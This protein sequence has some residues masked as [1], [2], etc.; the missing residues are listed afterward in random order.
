MDWTRNIDAYCERVGAAFWSEPINAV[1]NLAFIVA[2][3]IIWRRLA[4]QTL[5]IA[6]VL[7]IILGLIGVGSFLFHTYAQAWSGLADVL[8]I[9]GFVLVYCYAA[10]LHFWNLTPLIS[11]LAALLVLPYTVAF[12]YLFER[13]SFFEISSAYWPLPVLISLVAIALRKS[14]KRTSTGLL[15]GAGLLSVSLVF[16]SLDA[17]VC[18]MFPIGTHFL[19]HL[20]NAVMLAWMIET[21]RRHMLAQ[22]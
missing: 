3:F 7:T 11:G 22:R 14:T 10:C 20:L 21:Y 9:V 1:T 17:A 4:R 16:R 13:L 19:W 12:G 6:R 15:F 18:E 5:P 2:A 8:P